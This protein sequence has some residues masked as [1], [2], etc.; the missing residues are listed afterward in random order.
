MSVHVGGPALSKPREAGEFAKLILQTGH[1]IRENELPEGSQRPEFLNIQQETLRSEVIAEKIASGETQYALHVRVPIVEIKPLGQHVGLE[2]WHHAVEV[3]DGDAHYVVQYSNG[4]KELDA[5]QLIKH[6]DDRNDYYLVAR[7]RRTPWVEFSHAWRHVLDQA[8]VITYTTIPN[9]DFQRIVDKC[10]LFV[11]ETGLGEEP[12]YPAKQWFLKPEDRLYPSY[13]LLLFN[14]EH[15]ATLIVCSRAFSV[16]KEKFHIKVWFRTRVRNRVTDRIRSV[17]SAI[18]KK[19]ITTYLK[20]M[21]RKA[22]RVQT[23]GTQVLPPPGS[24]GPSASRGDI[25]VVEEER[26]D[27]EDELGDAE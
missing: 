21:F 23:D 15:L 9:D 16:Q 5:V 14:C 24:L 27:S 7:V 19:L 10:N 12:N 4:G 6:W 13:N 11:G 1:K 22:M 8:Q 3:V 25:E 26:G 18:A 17:Q 2:A 20:N